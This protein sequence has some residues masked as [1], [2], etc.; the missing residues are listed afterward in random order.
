[1]NGIVWD[2]PDIRAQR[3][4]IMLKCM[5][6]LFAVSLMAATILSGCVIL[7]LDW[8]GGGGYYGGGRYYRSYPYSPPDR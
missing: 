4:N 6:V 5:S 2:D 8:C 1:M 7:P 3:R